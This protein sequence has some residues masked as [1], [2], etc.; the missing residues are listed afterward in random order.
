[1]ITLIEHH[2]PSVKANKTVTDDGLNF[3]PK[4]FV[5]AKGN[6]SFGCKNK[7]FEHD[8]ED[9]TAVRD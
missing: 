5:Y 3:K 6:L 8:N 2:I 4:N 7:Q 9:R 1:M